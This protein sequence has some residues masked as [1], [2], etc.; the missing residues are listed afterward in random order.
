MHGT[1]SNQLLLQYNVTNLLQLLTIINNIYN[2]ENLILVNN[3][4]YSRSLEFDLLMQRIQLKPVLIFTTPRYFHLKFQINKNSLA[5]VFVDADDI[6]DIAHKTLLSFRTNKSVF[7]LK[8]EYPLE[9]LVDWLWKEQF[10]N[11][12]I[13]WRNQ[14]YSFD[15]FPELQITKPVVSEYFPIREAAAYNLKGYYLNAPAVQSLPRI[16]AVKDAKGNKQLSGMNGYLFAYFI[17]FMNMTWNGF[18]D[19]P[20]MFN[21]TEDASEISLLVVQ[22]TSSEIAADATLRR[23]NSYVYD[24]SYPSDAVNWCL[25]IP[26][27]NALPKNV[28]LL[29]PFDTGLWII[30]ISLILYTTVVF[31]ALL[32]FTNSKT[33]FFVCYQQSFNIITNA[34]NLMAL[35]LSRRS[36]IIF[37]VPLF[38]FGFIMSTFY[39]SFLGAF[40]TTVLYE[41][42]VKTID[43]LLNSNVKVMVTNRMLWEAFQYFNLP[44]TALR[45]FVNVSSDKYNFSRSYAY[46]VAS[47]TWRILEMEQRRLKR[48]IY[49][50]SEICYSAYYITFPIKEDSYIENPIKYLTMLSQQVGLYKAW[51]ERSFRDAING[52]IYSYVKANIPS[53]YND[54]NLSF[55]ATGWWILG[56]G[57]LLASIAFG[58]ELLIKTSTE[59]KRN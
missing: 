32:K 15:P 10:V 52:N 7:L 49:K 14:V 9:D 55:F 59:I 40:V 31:Y 48:P 11:S 36:W 37:Y 33:D 26:F 20:Q 41:K 35:R 30:L 8:N 4:N 2:Y 22:N 54:L 56:V 57:L 25:V 19:W 24:T 29:R 45:N 58:V 47:D 38:I 42:D 44:I 1:T 51:E 43:D 12:L 23:R 17:Q 46:F 39:L 27:Q 28:Y 5:I 16:F 18:N 53:D 13:L 34:P 21:D 6:L 3:G 50:W